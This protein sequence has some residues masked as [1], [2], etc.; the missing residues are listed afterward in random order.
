MR[1]P[2]PEDRYLGI[3]Q[4]RAHAVVKNDTNYI[5]EQRELQQSATS[6]RGRQDA[7][8]QNVPFLCEQKARGI[9]N[10]PRQALPWQPSLENLHENVR[11]FVSRGRSQKPVED[12]SLAD[13]GQGN[14]RDKP[15]T[16]QSPAPMPHRPPTKP[17]SAHHPSRA[18]TTGQKQKR[19]PI[20]S[21][22]ITKTMD[23][24]QFSVTAPPFAMANPSLA[25]P[26]YSGAKDQISPAY[27]PAKWSPTTSSSIDRSRLP[28]A[29]MDV[30]PRSCFDHD[31]FGKEKKYSPE[32]SVVSESVARTRRSR[33]RK[34]RFDAVGIVL[35]LLLLVGTIA[36]YVYFLYKSRFWVDDVE[37]ERQHRPK[38]DLPH[39]AHGVAVGG[40]IA[41]LVAVIAFCTHR[42]HA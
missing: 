40:V 38:I 31:S 32:L 5:R 30:T 27:R 6:F 29:P 41:S 4:S 39:W 19:R 12:C 37:A 42:K 28:T 14:H 33:R 17:A 36:A 34:R 16:R 18:R 22:F 2:Y 35:S 25:V 23:D 7:F 9:R 24:K 11:P 20:S 3:K 21:W 10:R 8:D 15:R 13:L 26:L 1:S